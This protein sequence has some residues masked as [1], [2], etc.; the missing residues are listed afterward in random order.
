[1]ELLQHNNLL[2]RQVREMAE[3]FGFETRNKYEVLD[4]NKAPVAYAAEQQKGI[5]GWLMR[6]FLGHWRKFDIYFYNN[7]KQ[8]IMHT[9]HPFRFYFHRLEI[10]DPNGK[11]IGCI[12]Q[13]FSILSKRF[14][15]Q[16]SAGMTLMEVASPIWKF[17][18]FEFFHG[19]KVVG[20]VRKKWSGLFSEMFTDRDNFLIEFSDPTLTNDERKLVLAAS[21]FIDLKYFERKAGN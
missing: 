7:Q 16:N 9:H 3:F 21:I 17:W 18:T 10:R 15:V 14:D 4:I 19:N 11:Y 13:R 2:V 5:L 1:M 12:Q 6:Q 20:A 8:I